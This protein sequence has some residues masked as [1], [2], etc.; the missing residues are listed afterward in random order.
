MMV[1]AD[2][3]CLHGYEVPTANFVLLLARIN[4]AQRA[5]YSLTKEGTLNHIRDPH[6]M[7]GIFPI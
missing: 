5:Q 1:G 3:L 7:Y 4:T 2:Q 6:I